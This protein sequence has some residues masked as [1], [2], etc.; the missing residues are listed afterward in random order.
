MQTTFVWYK[1]DQITIVCVIVDL[2][3]E[4]VNLDQFSMQRLIVWAMGGLFSVILFHFES[5]PETQVY[6]L[7]PDMG[8]SLNSQ[9]TR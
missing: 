6:K 9:N 5:E 7:S 4:E 1:P 8:G 2:G 3:L